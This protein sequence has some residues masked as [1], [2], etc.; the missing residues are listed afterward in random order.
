MTCLFR[1][2]GQCSNENKRINRSG[3]VE[4]RCFCALWQPEVIPPPTGLKHP[5]RH[6]LCALEYL[7][8]F[9]ES[10]SLSGFVKEELVNSYTKD[11]NQ[12]QYSQSYIL[13]KSSMFQLLFEGMSNQVGSPKLPCK[14]WLLE[15]TFLA[16]LILSSPTTTGPNM[17]SS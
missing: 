8:P 13:H 7:T 15:E 5:S 16:T 17:Q 14:W 4:S 6:H 2:M 3:V 9:C 10:T 12:S 11:S 1:E